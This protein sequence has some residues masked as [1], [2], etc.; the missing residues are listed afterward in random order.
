MTE[1]QDY[2]NYVERV[3]NS[4]NNTEL[5]DNYSAWADTYEQG[6]WPGWNFAAETL[7]AH[8][9]R[10]ESRSASMLM[11]DLPVGF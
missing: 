3:Y 2:I 7:S 9:S 4:R 5:A 11:Q 8:L 1:E 10:Q 6:S